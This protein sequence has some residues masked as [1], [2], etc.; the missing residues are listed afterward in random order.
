[1]Y[2]IASHQVFYRNQL[3]PMSY[4][5]INSGGLFSGIYPLRE[6]TASTEF[7]DGLLI[8]VPSDTP[9]PQPFHTI[10]DIRRSNIAKVVS[11]GHKIHLYRLHQGRL[12][13]HL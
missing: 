6:E 13:R 3:Y 5:E 8:P 10:D 7:Y 12:F 4:V 1:M 11:T 9:L 2:R